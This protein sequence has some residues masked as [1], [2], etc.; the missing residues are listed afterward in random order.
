MAQHPLHRVCSRSG[1][2]D[3]GSYDAHAV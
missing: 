2:T 3:L 1:Y